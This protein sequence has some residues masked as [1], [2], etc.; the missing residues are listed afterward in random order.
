MKCGWTFSQC[1]GAWCAVILLLVTGN[2][3]ALC[4]QD[5]DAMATIS[6]PASVESAGSSSFAIGL[7][8]EIAKDKG[9]RNVMVSPYSASTCLTMAFI[10]AEGGTKEAMALALGLKGTDE[11]ILAQAKQAMDSLR[12]PGGA[13]VLEIANA[14][15]ANKNI[16]FKPNYIAACKK[17]MDP[18]V[19]SMDFES[20]KAVPKI[21][22]WASAHTHGKIPTIIKEMTKDDVLCLLNAVYFKGVWEKKFSKAVTKPADFH[23]ADGGVKKVQMMHAQRDDFSY[24]ENENFKAVCLPYNDGRL[25]MY[26]FLPSNLKP[27]SVFEA[28]LTQA[29]WEDW[30][31]MFHKNKGSLYMPRF[32]I[33]DSMVLNNPLAKLGMGIA[34]EKRDA[35]FLEMADLDPDAYLYI[36]KVLQKTFME[37]NEEGTEAA[38]VTATMMTY[39]G[40]M[41]EPRIPFAM[42]VDKPFIVA[43]RDETTGAVLFIGHI[44]DPPPAS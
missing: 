9:N 41:A 23:T 24:A 7:F 27:L 8:R 15:F 1:F 34:F 25:S 18:E 28:E 30:M 44:V 36:S 31:R 20:P 6:P 39:G 3:A 10:G 11:Q 22:A 14:L 33:E 12:N 16:Q 42:I 26:V 2:T 38:A 5:H 40:G 37:V 21:N 13:T 29:K 19:N 17:Y 35:N 32:K 4:A 43:I